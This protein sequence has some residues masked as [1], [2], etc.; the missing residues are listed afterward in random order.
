MFDSVLPTRTARL[1]TAFSSSGR[2]NVRNA[3][4]AKDA[5]PLDPECTCPTCA[6]YTRGYLRHLVTSK[7]MLGGILISIHNLHFLIDL[8]SRAQDAITN[9][10]YARFLDSW[11]QSPAAADY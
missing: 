10:Q 11:I 5:G 4:F 2:L 3:K 8:M 6:G 9:G 1:A 7:E